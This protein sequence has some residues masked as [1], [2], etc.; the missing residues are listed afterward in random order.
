[1]VRIPGPV[2]QRRGAGAVD[3]GTHKVAVATPLTE[4]DYEY[5]ASVE[6]EILERRRSGN[7]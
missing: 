7:R 6:A 1:V 2:V 4:D 3:D 5:L